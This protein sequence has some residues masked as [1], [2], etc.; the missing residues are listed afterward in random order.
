MKQHYLVN[1]VSA[2]AYVVS[3]LPFIEIGS[4]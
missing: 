3:T 4:V 2:Y 1:F